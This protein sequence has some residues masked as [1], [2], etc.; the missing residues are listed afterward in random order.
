ME[1]V[2][3]NIGTS[4]KAAMAVGLVVVMLIG[5]AALQKACG[6]AHEDASLVLEGQA[7]AKDEQI[8]KLQVQVDNLKIRLGDAEAAGL[9]HQARYKAL[10][11]KFHA[12]V[13]EKP[14]SL[15]SL[16]T[17]VRESGFTPRSEVRDIP[18]STLA[19][20]DAELIFDWR[21][22]HDRLGDCIKALDAAGPVIANLE[23]Q[24][25]IKDGL[26]GA[27]DEQLTNALEA[28]R[29]RQ[30]QADHLKKALK[31]EQRKRWQKWA[32]GIGGLVVGYAAGKK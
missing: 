29:L 11:D 27:K 23:E 1:V 32:L 5:A 18:S 17:F 9:L 3:V 20:A 25:K 13:P 2:V 8:Q 22:S 6:K 26:I 24:N 10:L 16:T 21:Q 28:S 15:P 19:R 31:N 12:P 14:T 30:E 7:R 4:V